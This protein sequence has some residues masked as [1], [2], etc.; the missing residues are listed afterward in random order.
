MLLA[1]FLSPSRSGIYDELMALI[2]MRVI[3]VQPNGIPSMAKDWWSF[4]D[5]LLL[6]DMWTHWGLQ[7][8]EN[9]NHGIHSKVRKALHRKW[10][11][12]D[13]GWALNPH[14]N[15]II[16]E[17]DE[18]EEWRVAYEAKQQTTS[19]GVHGIGRFG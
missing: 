2:R 4:V 17:F 18:F 14:I 6:D 8:D 5:I 7:Q 1:H 11:R 15:D 19:D 16:F 9:N 10:I 12:D 3:V 13:F